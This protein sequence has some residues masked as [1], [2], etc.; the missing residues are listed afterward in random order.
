MTKLK[1]KDGH[2]ADSK[3]EAR[4]DNA[5]SQAGLTHEIHPSI[6]N[7]NFIAD[8]KVGDVFVEVW[9]KKD[10]EYQ[11]EKQKKIDYYTEKGL[12]NRLVQIETEDCEKAS[13]LNKKIQ[14]IK[15]KQR[16]KQ[17]IISSK[18]KDKTPLQ[19]ELS[20]WNI[21]E[22]IARDN[23]ELEDIEAEIKKLKNERNNLESRK[24]E[25]DSEIIT[26]S[27]EKTAIIQK[28]F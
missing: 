10:E 20:L 18:G 5:L 28:F 14:E 25:L 9:G 7:S 19:P 11:K 17:K 24:K 27:A 26:H 16:Q 15:D 3:L 4:V 23:G 12:Q 13:S 2:E 22:M 8:F 1:A 21:A 6:L